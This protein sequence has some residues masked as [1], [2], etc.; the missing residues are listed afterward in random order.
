MAKNF[1]RTFKVGDTG[2]AIR[3]CVKQL[4]NG[5]APDWDLASARFYMLQVPP[6]GAEDTALVTLINAV[7]AIEAPAASSGALLYDLLPGDT[8]VRGRHM[9]FFVVTDAAGKIETYPEEGYIWI[10]IED[11]AQP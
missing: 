3:I 9:G 6:Y 1:E 11:G 7:A 4:S 8:D 2:P 5:K 10:T